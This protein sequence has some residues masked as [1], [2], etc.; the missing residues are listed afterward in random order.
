MAGQPCNSM[1]VAGRLF[2]GPGLARIVSMNLR[3]NYA[4]TVYV[5][6]VSPDDPKGEVLMV[7]ADLAP[8][9]TEGTRLY[10]LDEWKALMV[11][12]SPP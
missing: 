3:L 9:S 4:G 2:R 1:Q 5:V 10:S 7:R 8:V 6:P 11:S 12:D